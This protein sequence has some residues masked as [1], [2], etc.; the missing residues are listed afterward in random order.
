LLDGVFLSFLVAGTFKTAIFLLLCEILS[1]YCYL[2]ESA[3][4]GEFEDSLTPS[5]RL[6]L[7]TA[8]SLIVI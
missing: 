4:F 1:P 5:G 7:T 3:L 8:E 2:C 6:L